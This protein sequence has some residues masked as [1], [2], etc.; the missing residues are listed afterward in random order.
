MFRR[1]EGRDVPQA[2]MKPMIREM[3]EAANCGGLSEAVIFLQAFDGERPS[4]GRF[5]LQVADCLP[6]GRIA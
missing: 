6:A 1:G 4:F 2:E 5:L 3:K